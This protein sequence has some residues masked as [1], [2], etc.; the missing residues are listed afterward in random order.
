MAK[1]TTA[2]ATALIVLSS[3]PAAA[4]AQGENPAPP[5]GAPPRE[6]A[7]EV[8]AFNRLL[9]PPARRNLPPTE[10]GIH[11][12]AA[13]G[14]PL[15]QAPREAFGPLPKGNAGNRVDWVGAAESGK[16]RP[17]WNAADH[18]AQ[19]EVLDLDI[20]REVKGSM[21]DVVYPHKKHTGLL[22]CSACHPALF[23]MQKGASKMSMAAIILGEG[24]GAC[25]GRVAFPVSE[26]RLCHSKAK[27]PAA[28][29]AAK[30]DARR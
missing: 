20:V 12:P 1:T 5:A 15:L 27:T 24:C 2:F 7:A 4:Y 29:T 3:L 18:Q 10:D 21:P 23:E 9:A 8:N 14:T 26:C 22:D 11:D 17:L 13:P 30:V 16:I 6:A 25:H 28:G 19:P